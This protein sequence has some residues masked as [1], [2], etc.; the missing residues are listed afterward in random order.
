M[1]KNINPVRTIAAAMFLLIA[2]ISPNVALSSDLEI[3]ISKNILDNF[4]ATAAP[5][6]FEYSL[7]QG[8]P[9]AMIVLSNPKLIIDDGPPGRVWLEMDYEAE[10]KLLG[11]GPYRGKTRPEIRFE[12]LDQ[13]GALKI[14]LNDFRLKFGDTTDLKM[15]GF[16]EPL[17]LPLAPSQPL[18]METKDILV[19]VKQ[20]ETEITAKGVKVKIDY[21]LAPVPPKK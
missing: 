9:A 18:D 19:K 20:A 21:D 1:K 7:V 17:Y 4:L 16:L 6:Q 15:D 5:F 8:A 10:S 13:R 2:F 3:T 14:T 11:L 12:Y